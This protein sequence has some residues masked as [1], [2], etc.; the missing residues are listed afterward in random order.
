[1]RAVAEFYEGHFAS[2]ATLNSRDRFE[3]EFEVELNEAAG[4]IQGLDRNPEDFWADPSPEALKEAA[5]A[6]M[7]KAQG[8]DGWRASELC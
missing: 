3:E 6:C 4:V 1:M 7:K 2:C 5:K 8:C